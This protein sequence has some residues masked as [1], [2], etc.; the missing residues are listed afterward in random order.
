V[1][2]LNGINTDGLMLQLE[3]GRAIHGDA[4]IHLTTVRGTKRLT[5]PI[6]WKLVIVDT[7]E[8]WFT[9]GRNEHH[10]HDYVFANKT[11]APLV[12]KAD[13]VGRSCYGD[14]LM[15]AVPI[16]KVE[17]GDILALFDT[18]AYQEVS[19]SNFDAIPRP[20]T[21]LVTGNRISVIRGRETEDDV[22]RRDVMPEHLVA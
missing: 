17:V 2:R 16:P 21:M 22:F 8:F 14:R 1:E 5:T 9:G 11:D 13:I 6:R 12:D 15:P 10:L 20:A 19:M 3:P 18:G 7:T 4:G